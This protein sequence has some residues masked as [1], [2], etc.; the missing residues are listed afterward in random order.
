MPSKDRSRKELERKRWRGSTDHV[1]DN[2]VEGGPSTSVQ[3][4]VQ[5]VAEVATTPMLRRAFRANSISSGD[6]N[7]RRTNLRLIKLNERRIKMVEERMR[8]N[9]ADYD[10]RSWPPKTASRSRRR[11]VTLTDVRCG[12]ACTC[13]AYAQCQQN[14]SAFLASITYLNQFKHAIWSSVD[15]YDSGQFG[16][17]FCQYCGARLLCGEHE[18]IKGGRQTP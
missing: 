11:S 14:A 5:Q 16:D 1:N 7:P 15:Y 18:K 12:D 3:T 17:F 2:E 10:Q 8:K 4:E 6:D 13:T 9:L